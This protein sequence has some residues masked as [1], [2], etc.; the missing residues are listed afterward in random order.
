MGFPS[1][2]YWSGLPFPFP[3]DLPDPGI[4][5]KSPALEG[6]IL[7][8]W[9][10]WEALQGPHCSK[11]TGEGYGYDA[12]LDEQSQVKGTGEFGVYFWQNSP[13]KVAN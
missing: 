4:E 12:N 13:E 6:R 7:Y 11:E 1:Q 8:H 9:A 5:L 2:E 3:R 10:T